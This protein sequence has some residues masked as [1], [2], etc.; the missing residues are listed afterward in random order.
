MYKVI[1]AS[2]SGE[3]ECIYKMTWESIQQLTY[4]HVANVE[5][6]SA[7]GPKYGMQCVCVCVCVSPETH[8]S[9]S[10]TQLKSN[11]VSI[12]LNHG[13]GRRNR[14]KDNKSQLST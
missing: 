2:S 12:H 5:N 1:K 11:R 6:A 10:V 3:H 14:H 7:Q 8:L 9:C 13:C 4:F